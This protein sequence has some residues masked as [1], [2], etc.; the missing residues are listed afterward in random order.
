M[1]NSMISILVLFVS[2]LTAK[3]PI[4]HAEAPVFT[5]LSANEVKDILKDFAATE[6]FTSVS[7][8]SKLGDIFG[9]EVGILAGAA[10][11]PNIEKFVKEA[12]PGTD[13]PV[14]P[15]AALFGAISVPMGFK[16]ELAVLPEREMSDVELSYQA[17]AIQWTLN[18]VVPLPVD[19][20]FKVHRT[21]TT[22]GYTQSISSVATKV[23]IEDQISGL[24][25]L[26]SK[27]LLF[28]EPYAGMGLVKTSGEFRAASGLFAGFNLNLLIFK[29]G[30]ELG[31]VYDSTKAS[32]KLSAGF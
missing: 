31:K 22:L 17:F 5:D 18:E 10:K 24:Q 23:E 30:L 32:L 8:A 16:F 9:F 1:K 27:N 7:P 13:F 19:L 26:V 11:V 20:A 6:V 25:V 29:L 14:L 3:G 12:D 28:I 15:H 21:N 2:L 4:A